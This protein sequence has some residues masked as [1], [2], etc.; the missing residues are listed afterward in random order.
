[1]VFCD[2]SKAFDHVWHAGLIHKPEAAG[3]PGAVLTWFW[4]YLSDRKQRVV[5]PGASSDWI[6]I[7]AGVPQ[8]SILGPFLFINDIVNDIGA[9]IR[10]FADDTSLFIIV[11]NPMTAADC[12]NSDLNVISQW[13]T[14]W[15]VLFNPTKTESL[16]FSRKMN[17]PF[18]PP[19]YMNDQQLVEVETLDRNLKKLFTQHLY[20]LCWNM[21]M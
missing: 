2:I 19:L 10:L 18:H 21:Q 8:G 14:S 9:N 6:Y 20:E 1:M 7:L 3:V 15:L 17:K 13:A 5:L 11:E 4:S 12:L 16:I